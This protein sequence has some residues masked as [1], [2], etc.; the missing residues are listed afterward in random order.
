MLSV[1]PAPVFSNRLSGFLSD[2]LHPLRTPAKDDDPGRPFTP[3]P[4][5]PSR[6]EKDEDDDGGPRFPMDPA[7]A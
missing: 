1:M 2:L 6:E 7:L 4:S 5:Q 3:P